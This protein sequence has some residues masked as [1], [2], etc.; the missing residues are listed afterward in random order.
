MGLA[1]DSVSIF[2]AEEVNPLEMVTGY[3]YLAGQK[4]ELTI[5]PCPYCNLPHTII[6]NQY[7]YENWADGVLSLEKAFPEK[8]PAE[9][10]LLLTGID[11]Q[12]WR[13]D[14]S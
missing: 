1:L 13:K 14:F 4:L 7:A 10:E 5:R 12:C 8:T 6:V 9:R 3:K 2:F 11:E